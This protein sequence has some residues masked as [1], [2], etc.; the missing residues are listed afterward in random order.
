MD[1]NYTGFMDKACFLNDIT[2]KSWWI[3]NL[4]FWDEYVRRGGYDHNIQSCVSIYVLYVNLAH[5][6][7]MHNMHNTYTIR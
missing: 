3:A 4:G 1:D 5:Y 6:R 2:L 7:G